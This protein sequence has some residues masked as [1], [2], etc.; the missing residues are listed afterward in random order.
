M[1]KIKARSENGF[2]IGSVC[3]IAEAKEKKDEDW[4]EKNNPFRAPRALDEE[5][6]AF[7]QD[8]V[9]HKRDAE[10]ALKQQ[11]ELDLQVFKVQPSVHASHIEGNDRLIDGLPVV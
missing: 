10:S 9:Q 4:K 11:D 6:V 8:Y 7:L 5:D 2:D 3:W 1:S